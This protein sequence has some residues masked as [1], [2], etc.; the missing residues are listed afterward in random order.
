MWRSCDYEQLSG[1]AQATLNFLSE[2]SSPAAGE[3]RKKGTMAGFGYNGKGEASGRASNSLSNAKQAAAC[4]L[5][6][7]R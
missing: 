3:K 4:R 2:L 6:V 7:K 1:G 5:R